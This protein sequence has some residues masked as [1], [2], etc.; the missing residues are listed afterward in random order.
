LNSNAIWDRERAVSNHSAVVRLLAAAG[1]VS[2]YHTHFG[3]AQG[4]ERQET[5][6]FHR[7]QHRGYHLDYCFIPESWLPRL[8]TV[9]VGPFTPWCDYSDHTPLVVE[10]T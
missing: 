3:E 4:H 6:F 2:V 7:H 1:L 10:F 9:H 8:A 5:F